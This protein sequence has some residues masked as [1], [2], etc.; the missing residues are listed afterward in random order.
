MN[1]GSA[2]LKTARQGQHTRVWQYSQAPLQWLGG[3]SF[4]PWRS[5]G[6]PPVYYLRNPNGGLLGGDQHRI[7]IEVGTASALEIRTQGATRLHPGVIEQQVR[8]NLA[9]KSELVWIAHPI[10]PGAGAD[11]RQQVQIQ[12]A[13]SARLAYAEIWTAGRLAMGELWQFKRLHNHL[14]VW[15]TNRPETPTL[16]PQPDKLLWLQ[17]QMDLCF[18]HEQIASGS[19]LGSHLCWGSLYLL[20]DWPEPDWPT[21][22]E[23]WLVKSPDPVCKGWILRQVGYQAETLWQNFRRVGA[24]GRS[25]R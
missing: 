9:P 3:P 8:I 14:Q 7:H 21:D 12:L 24:V 22:A 5:P 18:P 2:T 1:F 20:G 25:A 6:D 11:F 16:S 17:E 23:H 19:V 13:P 10:I 15:V 4:G